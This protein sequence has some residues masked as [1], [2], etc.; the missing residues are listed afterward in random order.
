MDEL[1]KKYVFTRL[2]NIISEFGPSSSQCAKTI[3]SCKGCYWD[4]E[5]TVAV[6]HNHDCVLDSIEDWVKQHQ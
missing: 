6:G 2:E 4:Y 1:E 3:T 5:P